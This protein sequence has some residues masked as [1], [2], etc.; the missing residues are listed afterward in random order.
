MRVPLAAALASITVPVVPEFDA[1]NTA[2]AYQTCASSYQKWSKVPVTDRVAILRRAAD[3]L[4]A[5]LPQLCALLVLEAH[6]TWGD[7]VGEVR[8]AV[9]FLRY[10]ADEAQRIQQPITL[11]G[12]TGESNVLQLTSRGVWVC[13]S[14]WN[15]PLAIFVGQVA[16]ALATGNTVLA[17]P[18]EQTPGVAQVAVQLLHAAG[19]PVDA[20]QLLPRWWRNPAWPVWCLPAPPRWPKSSNVRW[21]PKT[22]PSSR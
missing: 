14:P 13:I 19:V 20:L 11:P 15:F 18:A 12:V 4:Q 2:H 6:K 21:P 10:Y 8:E 5:Q 17:K 22:A 3:A 1:K 16:A 9:D 7:A